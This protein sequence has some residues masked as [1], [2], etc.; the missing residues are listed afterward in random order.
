M[1]AEAILSLG[2]GISAISMSVLALVFTAGIIYRFI[3]GC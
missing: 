2:L 3:I 1:D